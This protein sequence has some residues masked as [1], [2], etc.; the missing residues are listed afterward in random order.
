MAVE[1]EFVHVGGLVSGGAVQPQVLEDDRSRDRKD[2]EKRSTDSYGETKGVATGPISTGRPSKPVDTRLAMIRDQA[3]PY[4]PEVSG[5]VVTTQGA[6]TYRLV[7]SAVIRQRICFIFDGQLTIRMVAGDDDQ[8]FT[9]VVTTFQITLTVDERLA[10]P[11]LMCVI[12]ITPC[13]QV[14]GR[15][16]ERNEFFVKQ[17][18]GNRCSSPHD[19]ISRVGLVV[20]GSIRSH[21]VIVPLHVANRVAFLQYASCLEPR[22]L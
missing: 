10:V 14:E 8:P 22:Q 15:D 11:P 7:R 18:A 21:I 16:E 9:N 17:Q 6:S 2:R 12:D 4:R 1:D 5:H 13:T 19:A 3:H 20:G